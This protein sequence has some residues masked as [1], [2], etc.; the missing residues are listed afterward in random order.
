MFGR[1][2]D[3]SELVADTCIELL[4]E[5]RYDIAASLPKPDPASTLWLSQTVAGSIILPQFPGHLR[6]WM[7]L[8]LEGD[9]ASVCS[10]A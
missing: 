10:L 7:A 9:S 4:G 3:P 2:F 1:A 8:R 5:L 6:T